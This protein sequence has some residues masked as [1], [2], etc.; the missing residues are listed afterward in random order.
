MIKFQDQPRIIKV[1]GVETYFLSHQLCDSG[2]LITVSGPCCI[3]LH[4]HEIVELDGTP[5]NLQ[6][7]S[8]TL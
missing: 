5:F 8:H 7:P 4:E 3:L 6:T 2:I 1:D